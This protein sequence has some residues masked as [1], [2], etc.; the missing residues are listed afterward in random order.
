MDFSLLLCS[1]AIANRNQW[2]RGR[3]WYEL[4]CKE[5]FAKQN[6]IYCQ[7]SRLLPKCR[8]EIWCHL[9]RRGRC[10][11]KNIVF[12]NIFWFIFISNDIV[13]TLPNSFRSMGKRFGVIP[14]LGSAVI[15]KTAFLLFSLDVFGCGTKF[16][17][18]LL[19]WNVRFME[20]TKLFLSS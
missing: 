16:S 17:C 5:C 20:L 1:L 15:S 13:K 8:K 6:Q 4:I 14:P 19:I 7:A 9:V 3:F 10:N 2:R 18:L 12:C 11:E